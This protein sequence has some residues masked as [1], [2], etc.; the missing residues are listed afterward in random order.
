MERLAFHY[1]RHEEITRY[2][3]MRHLYYHP[4][5][6]RILLIFKNFQLVLLFQTP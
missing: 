5:V 4:T 6:M 2:V 3:Q 1:D